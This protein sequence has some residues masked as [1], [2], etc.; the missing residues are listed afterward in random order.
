[1]QL[2]PQGRNPRR[3]PW[4]YQ[5][6][7]LASILKCPLLRGATK[8]TLCDSRQHLRDEV[9]STTLLTVI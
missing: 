9:A 5:Q 8:R 7:E 2:P 4:G 6:D 1:M 3:L